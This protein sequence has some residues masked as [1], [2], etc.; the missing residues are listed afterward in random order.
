M[1]ILYCVLDLPLGVSQLRHT[2]YISLEKSLGNKMYF[3][4]I[5]NNFACTDMLS[6]IWTLIVLWESRLGLACLYT[7]FESSGMSTF[8]ENKMSYQFFSVI[9]LDSASVLF[10]ILYQNDLAFWPLTSGFFYRRDFRFKFKI[11]FKQNYRD[12]YQFLVLDFVMLGAS[13]LL[14]ENTIFYEKYSK[15]VVFVT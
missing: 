6:P 5:F 9:F 3:F 15:K 10:W 13:I 8:H 14:Y 2:L 12:W 7:Y 4:I 1:V 11:S